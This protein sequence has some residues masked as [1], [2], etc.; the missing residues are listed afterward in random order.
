MRHGLKS[1]LWW[2]GLE[3]TLVKTLG[4]EQKSE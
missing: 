4:K 1:E 2:L 3:Q